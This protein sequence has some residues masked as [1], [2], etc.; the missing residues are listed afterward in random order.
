MEKLQGF[1]NFNQDK[2]EYSEQEFREQRAD[3]LLRFLD[4]EENIEFLHNKKF[5][6]IFANETSKRDFID[7]LETEEFIELL[8]T[9]NGILRNKKKEDW[10]MDGETVEVGGNVFTGI[11]Y[12]A[13]RHEDKPEL[14]AKVLSVA[15]EMNQNERDLK[16]IA[17][18]ISS[19]INAIHSYADGN[20]RTSRLIYSLFTQDF[21]DEI[22][23]ELKEILSEYGNEKININ[24]ASVGRKIDNLIKSEVGLKDPFTNKDEIARFGRDYKRRGRKNIEFNQEISE[25]DKKSFFNLLDRDEDYFFYSV[26]KY[27]QDNPEI[28]K[29]KYLKKIPDD[30]NNTTEIPIGDL[31][32][33][34]KQEQLS[35]IFQNYRY[36]KKEKVKKLIDCIA[37][38]DKEEYQ[39]EIKGQKISMKD[40]F[41]SEIKEEQE[42]WKR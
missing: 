2:T 8:N 32:K 19:S 40:Y 13:P 35:Q 9:F 11:E 37:N 24:P 42:R 23:M 14:L 18:L 20:G 6:E 27:L 12:I 17:L 33:N 3:A 16:D 36:L 34:L 10:K 39:I 30:P 22:K 15:K 5:E 21:D 7:N 26:I 28:D 41:E 38:P 31:S 4:D 29:E 25:A 1:E